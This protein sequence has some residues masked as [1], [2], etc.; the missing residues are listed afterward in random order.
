LG[1][2]ILLLLITGVNSLV[3]LSLTA[4]FKQSTNVVFIGVLA[5]FLMPGQWQFYP[6]L[7]M[8]VL[9][10]GIVAIIV[11]PLSAKAI[12]FGFAMCIGVVISIF[13][14]IFRRR[15]LQQLVDQ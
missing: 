3:H 4:D 1:I 7:C 2:L 15:H 9:S 5:G 11:C 14:H 10:W 8:V 6:L 13:V 12:H